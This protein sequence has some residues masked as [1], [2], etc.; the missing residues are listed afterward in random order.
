MT[1]FQT[2]RDFAATLSLAGAAALAGIAPCFAEE[3]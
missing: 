1:V 3:A 2:R